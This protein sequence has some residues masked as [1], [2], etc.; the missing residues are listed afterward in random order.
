MRRREL[1]AAGGTVAAI[2]LAGCVGGS[3]DDGDDGGTDDGS[4]SASVE[5]V[6][7]GDGTRRSVVV[8]GT[9]EVEA[10]PDLALLRVGVE[11]RAETAGEA[12]NQISE[13]AEELIAA[14][15][16]Y[17]IDEDDVTTQRY[18][19]RDRIDRRA[20]EEDGVR[21]DDP[22]AREEYTYYQGSHT[23]EVKVRDVEA[24]GEVIDVAVDAGADE[25]G[26]VTF[27][28][29]EETRADLRE[30]ALRQAIESARE[31]A[32]LIAG[33][34]GAEIVEATV[35]D[36]SDGRVSPVHREFSMAGADAAATPTE[37][38]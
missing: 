8:T 1:L 25:V 12:R 35:V 17:G 21:P 28:L 26:R 3:A 31:E 18:W 13:G 22:E 6:T 9:G 19:V 5:Q 24:V 30:D 4:G 38:A 7:E 11:A 16:E 10:E 2:G 27:T 15:T 20:M 29:S 36:A 37:A 33:E 23:F 32:D 34:V 14:L